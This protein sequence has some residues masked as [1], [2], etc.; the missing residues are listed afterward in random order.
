M[1]FSGRE[2]SCYT[3]LHVSLRIAGW[4]YVNKD[5]LQYLLPPSHRTNYF[6]FLC[7]QMYISQSNLLLSL[8]FLWQYWMYTSKIMSAVTNTR[9]LSAVVC[10]AV[11]SKSC[12]TS[13]VRS[14]VN[15]RG[16]FDGQSGTATGFS[17]SFS[18]F[19]CQ[20]HSPYSYIIWGMNNISVNGRSSETYSHPVRNRSIKSFSLRLIAS[21]L[22]I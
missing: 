22:E 13:R 15:P 14:R 17:P 1:F 2:T 11:F 6:T 10:V 12:N 19:P 21:S 4:K 7:D 18:V 16:N 3:S 20:Y 5:R 8:K 9:P